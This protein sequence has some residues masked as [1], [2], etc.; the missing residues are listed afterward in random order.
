MYAKYLDRNTCS[1][2]VDPVQMATDQGLLYLLFSES[3]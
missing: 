1:Y 3:A 2:S